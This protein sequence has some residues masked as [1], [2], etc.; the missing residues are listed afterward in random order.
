MD[1]L[2]VL[3][4]QIINTRNRWMF[5]NL[6]VSLFLLLNMELFHIDRWN[7]LYLIYA[8][9]QF[10]VY[11]KLLSSELQ[12]PGLSLLSLF[13]MG[14]LTTVAL[15]SYSYAVGLLG[16]KRFYCLDTYEITDFVFRTS[17][18]MNLYYSL[19]ILLLTRF[20][21][22]C[23]FIVDIT[24]VAKRYNLFYLALFLYLVAFAFRLIPF[25]GMISSTLVQFASSLPLLVVFILAVYCGLSPTRDKYYW[26]FLFILIFEIVN[27][28]V[29]GMYKGSIFINAA[30]Y[31]LYYYLHTRTMGRK[32]INIS[33]VVLGVV[34][35]IFIVYI[36]YPFIV[37]K[38]SESGFQL[39]SDESEMKEVDNMEIMMRVLTL[40]YDFE[41]LG[42]GD[43]DAGSAFTG[44]MSAVYANALFY[45]DAYQNGF[46]S[47]ILK[48]SLQLMVPRAIMPNKPE[49]SDGNMTYSYMIGREFD[50]L[51]TSSNFTG[52]FAGSYFW[53]GWIG[54]LMMCVINAW[55]LALLL[56]TCFSDLN[57]LFA[58]I[59]ITMTLIPMMR[60][61]EESSD[62][63]VRTDVF[64]LIYAFIIKVISMFMDWRSRIIFTNP[65]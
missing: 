34:S 9:W 58:W 32:L 26:L 7:W 64:Y 39:N 62:G 23:L 54:A 46:H 8:L 13:F 4:E 31:L 15:P 57:N 2:E 25:L 14:A 60:C 41:S 49:G 18:A 40:D 33:T 43:E 29:A 37:I 35:L 30:M 51:A 47:D 48:M 3:T 22:N 56:K 65:K 21:N 27:A 36:V 59:I 19:F 11:G 5:I 16:E 63:G 24:Q 42:G 53:G 50:P 12:S 44:R 45:E 20:S 38:R 52:L 6:L 17:V 61:F 28:F 10:V 55:V 1:E